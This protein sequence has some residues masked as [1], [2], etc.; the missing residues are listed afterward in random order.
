MIWLF[1]WMACNSPEPLPLPPR[2]PTVWQPQGRR[3]ALGEA[4]RGYLVYP[5]QPP[6]EGM[7]LLADSLSAEV[8]AQAD[9]LA[10]EG[11]VAF[12]VGDDTSPEAAATYLEG[13]PATRGIQRR[14]L[15]RGGCGEP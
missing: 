5:E 9:D 14:C 10:R 15:R 13:L 12:V 11:W 2:Q 1:G 4:V 6:A 7:L 3:V 8:Q